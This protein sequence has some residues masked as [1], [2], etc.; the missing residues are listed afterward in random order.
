ME[1]W[2]SRPDFPKLKIVTNYRWIYDVYNEFFGDGSSKNIE[3]VFGNVDALEFS[4]LISDSSIILCPSTMEGYG[5]YINQ[6]RAANAIVISTDGP[7]M[8]ELVDNESGV[9]VKPS[10]WVRDDK[11]LLGPVFPGAEGLRNDDP[12]QFEISSS[13]ICD[14]VQRILSMSTYQREI[15]AQNARFRYIE[16]LRYFAAKMSELSAIAKVEQAKII[17]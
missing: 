11:Q 2:K 12:I 15:L 1:C 13:S 17:L 10:G 14:A 4:K 7:P 8:N 5:H 3:L 6:A 9:L 16:D